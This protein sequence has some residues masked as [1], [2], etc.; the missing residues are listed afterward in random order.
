MPE[1]FKNWI[2][3]VLIQGMAAHFKQQWPDFNES[4]FV[5]TAVKN[6]D[7]LELKERSLQITKAMKVHFPAD[8]EQAGTLLLK[9]LGTPLNDDLSGGEITKKG[10]AGWAIMSM[11]DYVALYG[12]EHFDTSMNLFK[13]LTKRS[14]SE[15]GIRHFLIDFPDKT[16][17]VMHGWTQDS[18][19]H[20]RRLA[21]EGSRPRLPWG[22][23]L[24]TY[25]QDPAPVIDLLEELKDD[26]SEYV[27]RSVANHLNDI[28]KDHPDR[29]A[30]IAEQWMVKP[31]KNRE[32]LVKHACRTLVKQGHTKTLEVLGYG[33]AVLE[34]AQLSLQP[35]KVAFGT[36]MHFEL[37]LSSSHSKDQNL[38]I[39]YIIH[40]QKANGTTSPKV[41]KWKTANLPAGKALR[42]SKK[43]AF[44]PITTRVYYPGLHHLEVVVNGIS[45]AQIDFE[46]SMP[47]AT[48]S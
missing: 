3:P 32:R 48:N 1:P 14:S 11:V 39:D 16:L 27:R 46:L 25:V 6:L 10:I 26:P 38:M 18:S 28:A 17:A 13:E 34:P 30:N 20:V 23:R 12:K 24:Q 15:F 2:N 47:H 8:F 7:T 42:L 21:S 4:A 44:K 41:F 29:V 22:L 35:Q 40:H 37:V 45:V 5:Q 43:H 31:S 19:P 9:S 36:A 33:T